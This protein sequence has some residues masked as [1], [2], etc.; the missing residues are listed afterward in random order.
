MDPIKVAV[1]RV[2]IK[3]HDKHPEPY[4]ESVVILVNGMYTDIYTND[5]GNLY[6][7][8]N[9]TDLI[10]YLKENYSDYPNISY[11]SKGLKIRTVQFEDSHLLQKWMNSSGNW[12]MKE[13]DYS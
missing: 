6:T 3:E 2:L 9:D 4:G 13:Q 1:P 5:A 11:T 10:N 12:L 8:T 7:M